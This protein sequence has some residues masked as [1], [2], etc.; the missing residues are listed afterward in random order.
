MNVVYFDLN[1]VRF[2]SPNMHLCLG[3]FDGIH[4]AHQKIINQA[5]KEANGQ[6]VAVMTFDKVPNSKTNKT[7]ILTSLG[8]KIRILSDLG[9]DYL[10]VMR[11]DQELMNTPPLDFIDKVL[12]VLRVKKIYCGDDYHFGKNAEGNVSFLQ[13]YFPLHVE[14]EMIVKGKR[15]S[16]SLICEFIKQGK[17][18]EANALLDRTYEISGKIIKGNEFGN[19]IGFP[20][21]NIEINSP[22][23]LPKR[24][25]Y[26]TYIYIDGK[27]YLSMSNVGV[28]PTINRLQNEIIETYIFDF[29]EDIYGYNVH[30]QF[31]DFIRDEKEFISVNELKKQLEKDKNTILKDY[32]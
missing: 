3:Y 1:S 22:Y 25:V 12:K 19:K 9:I 5:I 20:T 28:H 11:F 2:L 27:K 23:V 26:A 7:S 32:K 15:V 31:L 13:N 30:L 10:I 17:I 16:S 6:C 24:G 29:N 4:L 14:K 18:K 8:D 21:A